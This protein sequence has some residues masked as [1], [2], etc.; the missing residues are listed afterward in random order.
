ML[1][2]LVSSDHHFHTWKS[3]GLDAEVDLP[4][5]LVH[6]KAIASQLLR[7]AIEEGVDLKICGGDMYHKVGEIPVEAANIV[8]EFFDG[9]DGQGIP[10]AVVNGNHDLVKRENPQWF[11]SAVNTYVKR[12]LPV[13][14]GD[15][16]GERLDY[17][18]HK[19][20]LVHWNSVVDYSEL[21]G[22]DLVVLHKTPLGARTS[23]SYEFSEGV[24]WRKLA[25]HNGLVMF[26]H[27]H[28]RQ[29]LADNCYVIGS[30]MH[31]T[32][33]DKEDRGCWVVELEEG[34]K[35]VVDFR[36]LEYPSFYTV[37]DPSEVHSD[38]NYYRVLGAK[39]KI[40]QDNV[41]SVVVP[42]YFEER[43]QS[44]DL[45]DIL[46][47]WMEIKEVD[48]SYRSALDDVLVSKVQFVREFYKGR[49]KKVSIENFMS[50]E[51]AEYEVQDGF[52]LVTG[53]GEKSDSNGSGKTTV[54]GE[55]AYWCLFGDTTKGLKGDDVI[56]RGYKDC[57]VSVYLEGD[58]SYSVSR[59]RK[60]GLQVIRLRDVKD[61]T[62]G[63]LQKERQELLEQQ[64]LG[65]D[66]KV[67][68][69]ACY[70]SQENLQ[71][72]T[73]L[74]DQDK[75]G[76]V[77]DLL[78]FDKYDDLRERVRAELIKKDEKGQEI[79]KDKRDFELRMAS[80]LS[81]QEEIDKQIQSVVDS[82][83]RLLESLE[84][85]NEKR[86][87]V[88][89]R[90]SDITASCD[91]RSVS[92]I[93]T[94][95]AEAEKKLNS[96]ES[97]ISDLTA[98]LEKVRSK[99]SEHSKA[100]TNPSSRATSIQ[101]R[102][103]EIEGEI[104]KLRSSEQGVRC[105]SCGAV[106]TADNVESFVEEKQDR[107]QKLTKEMNQYKEE[108]AEIQALLDGCSKEVIEITEDRAKY[109]SEKSV[110]ATAVSTLREQRLEAEKAQE[111]LKRAEAD[112][113]RELSVLNERERSVREQIK[114]NQ[115]K[116]A[117]LRK[118]LSVVDQEVEEAGSTEE[119]FRTRQ[120]DL[121]EEIKRLKF[122]EESF[123][124]RG[125]RSVLMDK[126]CNAFNI[127]VNS[128]LSKISSGDISA[129][130]SPTAFTKT[131]EQR[132]RIEIRVRLNGSEALYGSLS[133]GE[134]RRVQAALCVALNRWVSAEYKL[135]NGLLG[136][137]IMDEV[138]SFVDR[139]GEEGIAQM[140]YDEGQS[141]AVYV[142]DHAL[143]LSS[144]AAR[145]ICVDKSSG[146][147]RLVPAEEYAVL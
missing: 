122:W 116:E 44:D 47:E 56:R 34:K 25:A 20:R 118:E 3:F 77:T 7:V 92:D 54:F 66:K 51:K 1:R 105:D 142:V 135:P 55:S 100:L 70:F 63:L 82:G 18:G 17:L 107:I 141:R 89:S 68:R 115:E 102:I 103:G 132:N 131:G 84:E 139:S 41:V 64:I 129:V 28:L 72:F 11:H 97:V 27:I 10:W 126:F 8:D 46:R 23:E 99:Q 38:G 110:L 62:E 57:Y 22:Y 93:D 119:V 48:P 69:A 90:V 87:E 4:I 95:I 9:L 94:E 49:M 120:A 26:G 19:I 43:I 106:V 29:Q 124:A 33:G 74:T 52:T 67:F 61:L 79:L 101:C 104:A 133:G 109:S 50:V 143:G 86:A 123:S 117:S 113:D 13:L 137:V 30:P 98:K 53:K 60:K 78:G 138:F 14:N 112:R 73:D 42:E 85:V 5:R 81:R 40:E 111:R 21:R 144:Y 31:F 36:K 83:E 121:D 96:V 58:E 76:M 39:E 140:L 127:E 136:V 45:E 2:I 145:I 88:S 147:S 32:F 71:M 75:T 108:V 35:P 24:D 130:I 134:K 37:T 146:V 80:V 114:S 6:Q 65:F 91:S 125:I 16:K 12:G 59:S 15:P 128:L